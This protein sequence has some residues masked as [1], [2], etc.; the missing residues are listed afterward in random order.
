MVTMSSRNEA[1][2]EEYGPVVDPLIQRYLRLRDQTPYQSPVLLSEKSAW[3]RLKSFCNPLGPAIS[4]PEY[5]P[6]MQLRFL[7]ILRDKFP[8]HRLILS[9]FDALPEAIEGVDGPVVQTRQRGQMV[10]CSTYLVTRGWFDIF[11]P[12]NFALMRDMYSLIMKQSG[13]DD[14]NA[15]VLSA[16]QPHIQSE[17][18]GRSPRILHHTEF[19]KEYADLDATTTQ[20]R[21]NPML[22]HYRN[23][24]FFL[25]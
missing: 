7:D 15:P 4:A 21:T 19:L 9:D 10:P 6:T 5:I 24:K 18:Q 16:A 23:V 25:T 13:S 20:S 2:A 11:F 17:D 14:E 1:L 8:K 12:T 22:E 3:M